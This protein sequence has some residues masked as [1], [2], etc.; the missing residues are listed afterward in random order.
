MDIYNFIDNLFGED[1]YQKAIEY[2]EIDDFNNL[3]IYMTAAAD[4][5][6]GKA[7]GYLFD[8]Y[9][10]KRIH[11][12]QDHSVTIHFYKYHADKDYSYSCNYL[13][14]IYNNDIYVAKDPAVAQAYYIKSAK[15]GNNI[16]ILNLSRVTDELYINH[17]DLMKIYSAHSSK[18]SNLK[19]LFRNYYH[20]IKDEFGEIQLI[21]FLISENADEIIINIFN[22]SKI[23]QNII[24]LLVSNNKMNVLESILGNDI[25]LNYIR[26][27]QRL[28]EENNKL[29]KKH[30]DIIEHL[31]AMPDGEYFLEAYEDWKKEKS[32]IMK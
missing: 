25:F 2:K 8:D 6:Y 9:Q 19:Q 15:R 7:I 20:K 21:S 22:K 16:A 4:K 30:D 18:T 29:R 17:T 11:K 14:W 24:S 31:R 27:N 5:G 32:D 3:F 28:I 13:G 23:P 10:C 26:E 12:K 1:L